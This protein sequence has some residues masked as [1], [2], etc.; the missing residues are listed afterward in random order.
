MQ[1]LEGHLLVAS[2]HLDDSPFSQAVILVL[3]HSQDGAFGVV[4]NRPLEQTVDSL[5]RQLSDQPCQCQRP[6]DMGGPVSGPLMALHREESLA[7]MDAHVPGGVYVAATKEHLEQLVSEADQ[8]CRIFVGHAGWNGGQL[9]REIESGVWLLAQATA[10]H[11]FG[12]DENLWR[13]T[14]RQIGR[15]ILTS[16]LKIKHIPADVSW[17]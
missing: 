2:P 15:A 6:L 5:W 11:V 16:T 9:E 8:P 4:L 10:D 12:E 7:E 14:I 1:S 3:Y 13:N 17:N